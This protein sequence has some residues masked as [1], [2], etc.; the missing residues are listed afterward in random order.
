MTEIAIRV[1]PYPAAV[2]DVCL[3]LGAVGRGAATT[4][5]VADSCTR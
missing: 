3:M 2:L 1:V 5:C 4:V